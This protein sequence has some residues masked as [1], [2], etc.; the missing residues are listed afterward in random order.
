MAGAYR[1]VSRFLLCSTPDAIEEDYRHTEPTYRYGTH[2]KRDTPTVDI[3]RDAGPTN[4]LFGVVYVVIAAVAPWLPLPSGAQSTE[5]SCSGIVKYGQ[6]YIA[7]K[8][9][10]R[11]SD[12]DVQVSGDAGATSTFEGMLGYAIC[13]ETESQVDFQYTTS[14]KCGSDVTRIG[15]LD[16]ISGSLRIER[17]D[18]GALFCWRL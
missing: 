4:L 6:T 14:L 13:A 17:L 2:P 5:L 18:R 15:R 1:T 8:L 7:D 12:R 10:L 3:G 11:F 9:R 16:K